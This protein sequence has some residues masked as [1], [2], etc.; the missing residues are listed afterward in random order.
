MRR[1]GMAFQQQ[2]NC[3]TDIAD[4]QK[5]QRWMDQ[6]Q[7]RRWATWLH[8]WAPRVM[9]LL[10][11]PEGSKPYRYY[12]AVREAEFAPQLLLRGPKTLGGVYPTMLRHDPEDF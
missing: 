5:A 6:F 9:P 12:W 3:F 10:S 4:P 11:S 8:R 2:G 1:A 7:D